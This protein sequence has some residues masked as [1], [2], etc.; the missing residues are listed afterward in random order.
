MLLCLQVL[1]LPCYKGWGT[2]GLVEGGNKCC[3]H[4]GREGREAGL[5]CKSLFSFGAVSKQ[6][7]LEEGNIYLFGPNIYL[8]VIS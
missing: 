3:A 4:V 8:C 6:H 1:E 5:G 2:W 7:V